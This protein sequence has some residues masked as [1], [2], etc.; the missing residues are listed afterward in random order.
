[1][2][3]VLSPFFYAITTSTPPLSDSLG[4]LDDC[5]QFATGALHGPDTHLGV[6][7]GLL[8]LTAPQLGSLQTYPA[9]AVVRSYTTGMIRGSVNTVLGYG[10]AFEVHDASIGFSSGIPLVVVE[11]RGTIAP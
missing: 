10:N 11:L 3:L 7:S 2:G 9:P 5:S 8:S 4:A 1:M 6:T